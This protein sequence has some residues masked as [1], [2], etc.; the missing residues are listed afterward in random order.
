[1]VRL[2]TVARKLP[3]AYLGLF[4]YASV[5]ARYSQFEPWN[6]ILEKSFQSTIYLTNQERTS[7]LMS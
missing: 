2:L 3:L 4:R 7:T 6:Y 5:K 1:M